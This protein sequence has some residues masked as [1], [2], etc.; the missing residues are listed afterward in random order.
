LYYFNTRWYDPN[1]GRFITEDPIRDGGNWFA[2]CGNNPLSFTDP[3]G[4]DYYGTGT[5]TTCDDDWF[6]A[7]DPSIGLDGNPDPEKPDKDEEKVKLGTIVETY[8]TFGISGN[9]GTNGIPA[10]PGTAVDPLAYKPVQVSPSNSNEPTQKQYERGLRNTAIGVV[11]VFLCGVAGY[12][13]EPELAS[14]L[15]LDGLRRLPFAAMDIYS[16]RKTK[17]NNWSAATQLFAMPPYYW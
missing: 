4:L 13:G 11:E 6:I 8:S 16:S 17:L 7:Y 12:Y 9:E 3:T 10:T 1:L 14:G 5:G 15:V 2:Y